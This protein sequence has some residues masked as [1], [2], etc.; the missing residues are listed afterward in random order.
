MKKDKIIYW[1]TTGIVGAMMLFSGYSYFSNQQAIDGFKQ[2]GFPDFFRIE[3]GIAKI[4]GALAILI[5]QVPNKVKEW[6]YA[7]LGITFISASIA[8]YANGDAISHTITPIVIL[9]ILAVSNI[10]LQKTSKSAA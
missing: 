6:A 3:L 8:H 5:P 4:L 7:G 1:A 9:G 2:I 10:Y